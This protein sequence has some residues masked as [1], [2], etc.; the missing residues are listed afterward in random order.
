M[1]NR[2]GTP[3]T[4]TIKGTTSGFSTT[5]LSK[6]PKF[7]NNARPAFQASLRQV[8]DTGSL[9]TVLDK[10]LDQSPPDTS[11]WHQ[12]EGIVAHPT[13]HAPSTG[14]GSGVDVQ[15]Q[16][17]GTVHGTQV[18][19]T[20][21]FSG[22][23]LPVK[24]FNNYV[25]WV[26]VYVQYLKAD[27]TNLSLTPNATFPDTKHANSVGLLPQVFTVL[28]VPLWDTNTLDATL[29]FPPEATSA[30]LLFCGLGS[31]AVDGGWRQYFP[32]DAYDAN[33]IGPTDEILVSSL[34]TGIVTL[35][36]TS[37]VLAMDIDAAATFA[38]AKKGATDEA[39]AIAEDVERLLRPANDAIFAEEQSA[40][41]AIEGLALAAAVQNLTTAD[42]SN[43][44]N[45]VAAI[46]GVIPKII[47]GQLLNA[48]MWLE[49]AGAIEA[50]EVAEKILDSIPILGVVIGVIEVLGDLATLV[51]AIAETATSPWVIANQIDLT[52]T[53]TVT[54]SH[55]DRVTTWPHTAASWQ[56]S[57]KIDGATV[58]PSKTGTIDPDALGDNH[59]V[60]PNLTVPFGGAT[61]TWAFVMLDSEGHQVGT[62]TTQLK[63]DDSA[64]PPIS[65]A[66]AI[67]ELPEVITAQTVFTRTDTTT[68][69]ST[70]GGYIWSK[71]LPPNQGTVANKGVQEVTGVAIATRLGVA[72]I[73]WK[74]N[75]QYWLRGIPV[76]ETDNTIHL[77][78]ATRQGFGA[79]PFLLFDSLVGPNDLANHVLL[80]PD[81]TGGYN[82]RR[83][84]INPT[85]GDLTWDPST[86][87]GFFPL[88][89]NAAALHSSGW[90]VAI[91][92]DT[93]RVGRV[94]PA[95]TSLL[96]PLARYTAGFGSEIGL[97]NSP[98]AV[99][100]TNPGVVIVLEAGASQLAAF[101]L[102]GNPVRYFGT[103]APAAFTLPLPQPATYLDVAVDGSAQIYV[104]SFRRDGS[105]PADYQIDVYTPNGT[106]LVTNSTG[107]NVPHIAVDY[108]RSIFAANYTAL[109]DDSGQP[110]IDPSLG[111]PEPSLSVLDPI[112]P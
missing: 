79:R 72:G 19:L 33:H 45:T 52:Y 104:L 34:L 9:G 54:V 83:L 82:V 109:L 59:L 22:G 75:D 66:F 53:A 43:I 13:P 96:P 90:V 84:T 8:R 50:T 112:T 44:W 37:F 18:Q 58:L 30:R 78:T 39:P 91:H 87:H 102:N 93:G 61:I 49:L 10:P 48:P 2:D 11:T 99:A 28:G 51:E 85:T 67:T 21:A 92:T 17:P 86:S 40:V 69:S 106:P 107:T 108:W 105:Q 77:G 16:N 65:V 15:V 80:E 60:I 29:T 25:R 101:D 68:F 38:V 71:T 4:I 35:G 62:A 41:G 7:T 63:N 12:P 55:D 110:H 47:F 88:P 73:V 111:V 81:D 89:V 42:A 31:D 6:D 100:V 97:L 24:L 98:T 36:L 5:Q 94:L 27:G 1:L 23:Q 57:A 103:S 95:N 14:L 32:P 20:G 26:W 64:N 56:I 70:V 3:S 76:A 46:A 74:Q